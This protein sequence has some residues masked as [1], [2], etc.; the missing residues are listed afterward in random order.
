ME[1]MDTIPEM[2]PSINTNAES[3]VCSESEL[4]MK[5]NEIG[6]TSMRSETEKVEK[7][8]EGNT[9]FNINE[10]Q[11]IPAT[12][13][14]KRLEEQLRI[15]IQETKGVST[16][17]SFEG[18]NPTGQNAFFV[19]NNIEIVE[20]ANEMGINM[21]IQDFNKVGL[22]KDLEIARHALKDTNPAE[23]G[24]YDEQSH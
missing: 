13:Q 16:K 1:T 17:M 15:E 21:S 11:I 14:S 5:A 22:M 24:S 6:K 23:T 18:T 19:L 12:R 10:H 4:G 2:E 9:S 20:L 7:Q 8:T 3:S